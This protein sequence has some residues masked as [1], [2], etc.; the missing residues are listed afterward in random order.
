[1]MEIGTDKGIIRIAAGEYA[2]FQ[3]L[4][5][6]FLVGDLK[7]PNPHPFVRDKRIELIL[8]FYQAGDGGEFHWHGEVTEYEVVL[9]G[10]IAYIE[11]ANG[12]TLWFGPGDCSVIPPGLCVKRVVQ[13]RSR[14]VAIKVPSSAE[15]V[16]CR[17]CRRQC[18]S[19]IEQ[20]EEN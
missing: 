9:E 10:R 15:K 6:L 4:Q 5:H 18:I 20:C 13:E 3:E 17:S 11:A 8:C 1:M 14:T 7:R 12:A 2:P 16:H 19:R